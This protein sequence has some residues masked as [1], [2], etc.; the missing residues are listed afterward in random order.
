MDLEGFVR[1]L[2][3]TSGAF[4]QIQPLEGSSPQAAASETNPDFLFGLDKGL[5]PPP[6]PRE[7]VGSNASTHGSRCASQGLFSEIGSRIGGS[8]CC[9]RSSGVSRGL[10]EADPNGIIVW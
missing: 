8:P 9:W 6:L 10:P 3:W 5:A 7:I 4:V 1:T 2:P